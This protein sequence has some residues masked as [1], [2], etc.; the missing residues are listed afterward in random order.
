MLAAC[1]I[2]LAACDPEGQPHNYQYFKDNPEQAKSV[3]GECRLNGTRGMDPKRSAVCE[4]AV[5][6]E[7]STRYEEAQKAN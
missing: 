4:A 7:K 1:A 6:A 3:I 2:L 5:A